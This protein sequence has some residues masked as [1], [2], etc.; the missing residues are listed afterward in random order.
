MSLYQAEGLIPVREGE[1]FDSSKLEKFLREELADFPNHPLQAM[2][3]STGFSNLTYSLK[4]GDWEAVLRRPPNGPLPRKAHDM[5]REFEFLKKIHPYFSYVPKAYAFCEDESILGVPFYV[6]ERKKGIVLDEV[7]PPNLEIVEEQLQTLSS[8]V[9]DALATLHTINYEEAGLSDFGY[10]NGFLNRQVDGWIKR[11]KKVQTDEVPH[12]AE[13]SKWLSENVPETL[14]SAIIHNDYKLNNMLLSPDL[15]EIRAILDWEMVTIGNP[16]FD[17][18]SA[19]VYWVEKDD[20]ETLKSSLPS[21]TAKHSGFISREEFLHRYAL[22]AK[23]DIPDMTFYM[24]INYF[25]LAVALQQIY[26]RYK[27]GKSTDD[28]FSALNIR[29]RNL[30][31]HAF[32]VIEKNK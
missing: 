3:F 19:V 20:P 22:K 7:F 13:V 14:D 9:V 5:K 1:G 16:Y 29:V 8:G 28:R 32:E 4:S 12:I 15:R 10:P 24:A 30:V 17:L 31:Y 2:Q 27:I 26:Y 23:K 6:M 11:Y 21:L 18:G 25:K